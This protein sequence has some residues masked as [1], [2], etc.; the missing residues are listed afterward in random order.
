MIQVDLRSDTVTRPTPAMREIIASAEVGDDIYSEDPS[1]NAL[2]NEMAVLFGKEAGLFVPTGSM[3][4]QLALRAHTEPGDEVIVEKE[5]HI[6]NYETAGPSLWSAVQLHTIPGVHGVPEVAAVEDA[7]RPPEYYYP[8]TSLVCLE[9]TH[10][11][12]GGT[13]FPLQRMHEIRDLAH[14]RGLKLHLDGARIWNAHI[15]TGIPLRE[16][17]EAVDSINVC[18]SKG[19]GAPI[20][21]MLLGTKEMIEKAHRF[22]KVFG[23]AMR[24]VGILAAAASYAVKNHLPLL[25]EDHRRTKEFAAALAGRKTFSIDLEHVETNMVVMDF[26]ASDITP[27]EAQRRLADEGVLIGMG[28]G[29]SLRAVFHLDLGD[30]H[31][32]RAVEVFKKLFV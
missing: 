12:A 23:G 3:G 9:N 11:R 22:R 32:Q 14:S 30:E 7:I 1:V 25:A 24:Q 27:A 29:K 28:R 8:R 2:Q 19:L 16:Y 18:F 31:L 5:C 21:S 6:F 17:G 4:N 13:V 10:N 15:A 20:G 26:S